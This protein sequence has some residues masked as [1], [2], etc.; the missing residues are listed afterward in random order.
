MSEL[1]K[2]ATVISRCTD[3]ANTRIVRSDIITT[4]SNKHVHKDVVYFLSRNLWGVTSHL[5]EPASISCSC[6]FVT[7]AVD[8][9]T[10]MCCV[11][12]STIVGGIQ[13][14]KQQDSSGRWPYSQSG[15]A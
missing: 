3:M 9:G 8:F 2:Q 1:F 15:G 13:G 14:A 6:I 11:T 12:K 10:G 7:V 5:I 4:L